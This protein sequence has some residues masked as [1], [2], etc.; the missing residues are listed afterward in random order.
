MKRL[1]HLALLG[2]LVSLAAGTAATAAEPLRLTK[3]VDVTKD[4]LNPGRTYSAPNLVADPSNPLTIV[5][6]FAELR[7]RRCGLIRTTDG[8]QTWTRLEASPSPTSYP[9]CNSNPRGT[10]QG[11]IA[12]GR[13]GA[14]YYALVGWDTQDGGV[15]QNVSTVVSR[16]TDLGNSWTPVVARDNRNKVDEA[17]EA[18][19]PITGL[20]V[21][22][23][24]GSQDTLYVGASRR[25][26]GFS[27]ANSLPNQPIVLVSTDAGKTFGEPINLAEKAFGDAALRQ[28]A[29]GAAT[30]IPGTTTT[31]AAAGTRAATQDQPA[32]FGG[33]GPSMVVDNKGTVY[34]VWPATTANLNPRPPNGIFVSRS[35]DKG[36]TWTTFQVTQF[37][38]RNGSFVTAAWSPKGGPNGTLFAVADGFENAAVAGYQ[39]IYVYRSTDGGQTWS[40]RVNVTDDDPKVGVLSSQFY[41][42][43]GVAPNGRVDVVFFDTRNDPGIRA[44]DVYYVSST[45]N[46]VTWGKNIRVTDQVVDRRIGVW[47]NN[48]DVNSPPGLAP[49]D[50]FALIAWDDT[51]NGDE[52]GQAQDIY[53]V[54][55]QYDAVGGGTSSGVKG[56]L[57]AVIGL[58]A[59]GL[60]LLCVSLAGRNTG[61]AAGAKTGSAR[62]SGKAEQ[63]A[64]AKSQT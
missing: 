24:T 22:A 11:Q 17:R 46:G 48:A 29:I 7:T 62:G 57:A 50:D 41:P 35:T 9:S 63:T 26:P 39:D 25:W 6:A 31:T 55:V 20:A 64:P 13:D 4:D 16:S 19:R 28:K 1:S 3:P 58:A 37:E 61:P 2:M 15:G 44:N 30:T 8:G 43:I 21:D 54:N 56:A 38:F 5:G 34:A 23:R 52:V 27:G 59:V 10:F 14:L 40:D 53:A 12:F 33:F 18:D 45:D 32:N 51:R 42:T 49:T 47:A 60:V 36:Q